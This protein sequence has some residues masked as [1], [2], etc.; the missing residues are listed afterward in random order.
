MNRLSGGFFMGKHF[1]IPAKSQCELCFALQRLVDVNALGSMR[2][3]GAA[4]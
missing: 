2:H 1:L 4:R 3:C